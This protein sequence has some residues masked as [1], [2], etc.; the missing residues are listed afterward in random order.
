M[1]EIPPDAACEDGRLSLVGVPISRPEVAVLPAKPLV[2][3]VKLVLA[4]VPEAKGL[5]VSPG[6]AALE[7]TLANCRGSA[8]DAATLEERA[9]PESLALEPILL[10]EALSFP[11]PLL[12]LVIPERSK[13]GLAVFGLRLGNV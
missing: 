7:R 10:F 5:P 13:L 1:L 11:V 6:W 9:I 4:R 2:S 8:P 3:G 12:V